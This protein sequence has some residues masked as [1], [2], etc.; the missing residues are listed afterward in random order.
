MNQEQLNK[1]LEN[2]V[3][4]LYKK[5]VSSDKV[6]TFTGANMA[7]IERI[8]NLKSQGAQVTEMVLA[9]LTPTPLHQAQNQKARKEIADAQLQVMQILGVTG[10]QIKETGWQ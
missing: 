6:V 8:R 2:A 1:Q 5:D 4:D 10:K 3:F 9:R 7:V